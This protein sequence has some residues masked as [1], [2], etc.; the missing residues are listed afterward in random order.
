EVLLVEIALAQDVDD[1]E[2]QHDVAEERGHRRAREPGALEALHTVR[3]DRRLDEPVVH[4]AREEAA[5]R[6]DRLE[7]RH[8]EELRQDLDTG[9]LVARELCVG[10]ERYPPD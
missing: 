1:E 7:A 8:R 6:E 5:Q 9:D 10:L 2:A 4:R 3:E